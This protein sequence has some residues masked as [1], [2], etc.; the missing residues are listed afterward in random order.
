VPAAVGASG[1]LPR[2]RLPSAMSIVFASIARGPCPAACVV[3]VALS[4]CLQ[5]AL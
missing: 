5:S 3:C 2:C 4:L 1:G